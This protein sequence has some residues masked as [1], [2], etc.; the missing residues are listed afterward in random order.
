MRCRVA[1]IGWGRNS[2]AS[3]YQARILWQTGFGMGCVASG[4]GMGSLVSCSHRA[5]QRMSGV[6]GCF[7]AATALSRHGC[8][9]PRMW[10]EWTLKPRKF[11]DYV[12]QSQWGKR[13][14]RSLVSAYMFRP[15]TTLAIKPRN[16]SMDTN[17]EITHPR[18][19]SLQIRDPSQFKA[20]Q[21]CKIQDSPAN[22][23]ATLSP[24]GDS[25]MS[26]FSDRG[27][28]AKRCHG[29]Q[30]YMVASREY[31]PFWDYIVS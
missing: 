18:D 5:A 25:A 14:R 13:W 15:E 31:G 27:A 3:C 23:S 20:L 10:L 30:S 17:A 1:L 24:V 22:H 9:G 29:F 16:T 4:S 28:G 2:R 26:P 8:S 7:A 19:P 6:V 21:L 12:Q 11:I